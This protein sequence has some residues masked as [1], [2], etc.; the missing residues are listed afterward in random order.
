VN[1]AE[2]A[3]TAAKLPAS[4]LLSADP[5]AT[6]TFSAEKDGTLRVLYSGWTMGGKTFRPGE[7]AEVAA[8]NGQVQVAHNK[9]APPRCARG[10]WRWQPNK[11]RASQPDEAARS[12]QASPAARKLLQSPKNWRHR[13]GGYQSV[14]GGDA[15]PPR[16]NW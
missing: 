8:R 6:L 7:W 15:Q 12:A 14:G 10:R 4:P 2:T 5:K 9:P 16:A 11:V 13:C 1:S 3:E